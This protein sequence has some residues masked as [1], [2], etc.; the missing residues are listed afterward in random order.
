MKTWYAIYVRSR[1]EK[2]T[3]EYLSSEGHEVYLPLMKTMRQWSDRRKLVEL[4]LI[5]CYL[6]VHIAQGEQNDI[7]NSPNVVT[8]VSN[9]GKAVA[10]PDVQIAAM[11]RAVNCDLPMEVSAEQINEGD[12]VEVTAGALKGCEGIYLSEKGK[13]QFVIAITAIGYTLRID[14]AKSCVK[15]IG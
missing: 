8:F 13:H 6:F 11:K 5:S 9:K 14:V 12:L 15:K 7:L 10:I 4:P 2:K 3:A 1:S